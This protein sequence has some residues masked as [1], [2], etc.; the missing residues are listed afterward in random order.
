MGAAGGGQ[1]VVRPLP[2]WVKNDPIFQLAQQA[3]AHEE[4][5]ASLTVEQVSMAGSEVVRGRADR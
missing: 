1:M 5:D 2:E 3:A 4:D